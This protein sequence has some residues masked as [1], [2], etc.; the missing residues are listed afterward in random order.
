MVW[1]VEDMDFSD[2]GMKKV[3]KQ[4]FEREFA[5]IKDA[6][7]KS[8]KFVGPLEELSEAS[9]NE[10][11][12][13]GKNDFEKRRGIQAKGQ[14]ISLDPYHVPEDPWA[15]PGT[16]GSSADPH[17]RAPKNNA[18]LM[19]AKR[20][21]ERGEPSPFRKTTLEILAENPEGRLMAEKPTTNIWK[22][23]LKDTGK[24]AK[25]VGRRDWWEA[26]WYTPYTRVEDFIRHPKSYLPKP[27]TIWDKTKGMGS[28]VLKHPL[29]KFGTRVLGGTAAM[30]GSELD[31]SNPD[32]Y[33]MPEYTHVPITG[34]T[35]WSE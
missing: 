4:Q 9:K 35:I 31:W 15:K 29:T 32:N 19:Q 20:A 30:V 23:R 1:N 11:M 28:K 17:Y 5:R 18:E 26:G 16:T 14:A 34:K 22:R 8:Q 6:N 25:A 24:F 13:R 2:E 12:G 33:F 7:W 3:Q 21:F 10:F 27:T